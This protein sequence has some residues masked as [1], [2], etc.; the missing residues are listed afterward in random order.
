MR[1]DDDTD[2]VRGKGDLP[3][4]QVSWLESDSRIGEIDIDYRESSES[5]MRPANSDVRA[6]TAGVPHY[7]LHREKYGE[8]LVAWWTDEE[9]DCR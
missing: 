7:C 5:H 2:A 4:L 3:R 9:I 8:R 1:R 6:S